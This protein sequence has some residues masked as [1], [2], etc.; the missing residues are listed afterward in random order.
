M[1]VIAL[2]ETIQVS[3]VLADVPLSANTTANAWQPLL[4]NVLMAAITAGVTALASVITAVGVTLARKLGVE[5]TAQDR[6]NMDSE[7]HTALSFGIAKSLSMITE[8]G[9]S[10]A[11]VHD[12]ILLAATDYLRQRFPDRAQKLT[13]QA[14]SEH[15][16]DEPISSTVAIS[17]TLLARLPQAIAR[18]AASPATPPASS[19]ANPHS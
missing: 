16:D 15:E 2:I 19:S 9:W 5:L 7:L 6:V 13:D 1:T 18:A 10:S 3:S 4:Q 8:H 11:S 17:Q 14:Q 12:A